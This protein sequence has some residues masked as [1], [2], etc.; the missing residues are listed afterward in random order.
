M[1]FE[2]LDNDD[3]V[4]RRGAAIIAAD[5]RAAV[6]ARGRFIMAVSGGHTPWAMLRALANEEVPWADVHVFQV[7]E[8]V[9][10]AGDRDRNLTHLRESLLQHAPL[11]ERQIYPMPVE[12]ADLE[13]A[14]KDYAR[15]LQQVA[16]T[17][18]VLDLAHLGMG[19]D[20]HTASLVPGDPVL[21]I[22]GSDVGV[23]GIYQ[24]RRRMTL[25]YPVLNRSR[26]ILWLITG[27]EKTP[28]LQQLQQGNTSIPA[29]RISRAQALVL[30]DRAAAGG[31]KLT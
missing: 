7:D 12:Q 6:A 13:A 3:A 15:T 22:T 8:R 23:T 14:A 31:L 9:A 4:A 30:A 19:P 29:G 27:A 25:T 21:N 5:A 16:G 20:G 11:P 18:A 17:P 26:R 1:T 28:M 10:P 24:G 2:I